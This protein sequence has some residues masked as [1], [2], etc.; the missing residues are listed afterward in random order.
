MFKLPPLDGD[1]NEKKTK[2]V[3][4]PE[5]ES[6]DSDFRKKKILEHFSEI[7]DPEVLISN[8]EVEERYRAIL[9][10]A[11]GKTSDETQ[12]SYEEELKKKGLFDI[13]K[14]EYAIENEEIKLDNY[15]LLIF[16]KVIQKLENIREVPPLS[17]FNFSNRDEFYEAIADGSLELEKYNDEEIDEV[18]KKL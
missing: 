8:E 12:K 3:K 1:S 13:S 15:N 17:S 4:L 11:K 6:L 18:F 10:I 5:V 16:S 7:Q 9:S 2:E 14:L